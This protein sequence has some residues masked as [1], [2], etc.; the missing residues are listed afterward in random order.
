MYQKKQDGWMKHVDFLILNQLCLHVSFVIAYCL[1][2]GWHELPYTVD[3]YRNIAVVLSGTDLLIALLFNTLHNILKRG[4]YQEAA[5]TVKHVLLVFV[6][7]TVY[8]FSMKQADNYSRIVL[9]VTMGLYAISNYGVRLIWK[10]LLSKRVKPRER[11]MLLV[12]NAA[13]AET[14][15]SD[16]RA[17]PHEA[18][19]IA[20]LALLDQDLRGES[21]LGVPVVAMEE[22][23]AAY[24]CR[25]WI[26]EVFIF[27][28]INVPKPLLLMEQCQEMGITVHLSLDERNIQGKQQFVER[29]AGHTVLTNSINSATPMQAFLKRAMDIAGGLVGCMAAGIALVAIGPAIR[30]QSPG[31]VIF[32]QERIGMNGRK[33]KFYKIRSMYLDAEQRKAELMKD[34]RV[35]DGMMFKLDFDPRIIG[36]EILPDGTRKTGIG[37]FIR[38]YSLDELPQ[39]WN[40]LKGDMS[41]VGTRPPT[42][43]EW[44]KYKLHHRARLAMKPGITGMWQVSGRSD[45]TDFEEVVKL[46]TEYICNWSMGLDFRL[47]FKT[48]GAVLKKRG[49]M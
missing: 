13:L 7:M 6:S 17:R 28:P 45:I 35:S 26:D 23:A 15:I 11:A 41:L 38:K 12:T 10:K 33:F 25:E 14:I 20:G 42:V 16:V 27:L 43:D 24:V 9:Y 40:V 30:R 19:E 48:V 34:N 49:A 47:L 4:Y 8:L 2:H 39:F 5:A 1:R 32:S 46:D 21:I 36:N 44:E 18:I 31:P 29:L 3:L 22:D 37:E